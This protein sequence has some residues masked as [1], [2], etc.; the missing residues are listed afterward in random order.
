MGPRRS[1]ERDTATESLGIDG[2]NQMRISRARACM[3]GRG[4][5]KTRRE[6]WNGGSKGRTPMVTMKTKRRSPIR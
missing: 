4:L 1:P 3:G 6:L 5:V 2:T